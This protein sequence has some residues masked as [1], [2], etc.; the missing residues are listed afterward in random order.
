VFE[1]ERGA[2]KRAVLDYVEGAYNVVPSLIERSVH[3]SLAKLGFVQQD[4]RYVEHPMTF[5][6]LVEIAKVFNKD[7]QI[8]QDA[9]RKV[10]VYEVLDQMTSAKL[11]AWWG[12]DYLHLAKFDGKWMIVN[13]LWQTSPA[14]D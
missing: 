10:T 11:E 13:V 6:E 3:P 7:G 14:A 5:E 9:P 8:P 4:G 2:V 1:K 12:V